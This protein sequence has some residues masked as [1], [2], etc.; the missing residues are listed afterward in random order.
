MMEP[1]RW[2]KIEELYHSALEREPGQRAVFLS[3]TCAGDEGLYREVQS[4]L[5]HEENVKEFMEAP[6]LEVAGEALAKQKA[7]SRKSGGEGRSLIGKTVSHFRI[8]E[9]LG[10]G[11]MG[12]VYKA[13]DTRLR[14]L[15]AL[16]FLPLELENDPQA[17]QRLRREAQAAS[18]LS[19]PNIC[20]IHDIDEADGQPFIAMELLEGTSLEQRIAGRP[21][22]T[23]TVID[24]AIQVSDALD[25][26]HAK[27]II[28]RDIK[29]ENIFITQRGQAKV[30]DFGIAKQLPA[31]RSAQPGQGATE[32]VRQEDQPALTLSGSVLGTVS[33]MSPEQARGEKLDA[34]T[35]LFSFGAVLYEMATGQKAFPGDT[36]ALVFDAILNREPGPASVLNPQV[37]PK[38]EE[39][40][41]NALEKDPK[42]RYQNASDLRADLMRLKRDTESGRQVSGAAGGRS[43]SPSISRHAG[44]VSLDHSTDAALVATFLSGI[45]AP[46][47]VP[48]RSWS[49]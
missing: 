23:G 20:T 40:I 41:Q 6:A 34:R 12:V 4:L 14:R 18:A 21:L 29:P 30:L 48:Q 17:F 19:H 26:A 7:Q 46:F 47:W 27:G 25:A 10:G 36:T 49:S 44:A 45:R 39:I 2:R 15:V 22:E 35:D 38:L 16:K 11:G 31:R 32:G 42:L 24:L 9:K 13:E 28:H 43:S 1:E 5:D 3:E 8:L 33:Y 37:P